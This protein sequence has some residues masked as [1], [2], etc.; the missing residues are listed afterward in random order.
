MRIVNNCVTYKKELLQLSMRTHSEWNIVLFFKPT[1]HTSCAAVYITSYLAKSLS[2]QNSMFGNLLQPLNDII[3]RQ[4]QTAIQIEQSPLKGECDFQAL[5]YEFLA[6]LVACL[7][8]FL[9]SSQLAPWHNEAAFMQ[10]T[11]GEPHITCNMDRVANVSG[12][13]FW[14]SSTSRYKFS[15]PH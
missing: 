7:S 2:T 13:P 6:I 3:R 4:K 10:F 11:D 1:T 14:P 12:D 5:S 8:C 15:T 9:L